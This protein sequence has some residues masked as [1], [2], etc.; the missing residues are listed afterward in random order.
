[1]LS[2]AVFFF[3]SWALVERGF[4][5][6]LLRRDNATTTLSAADIQSRDLVNIAAFAAAAYCVREG[7]WNCGVACNQVPD[8]QIAL[9]IG[10]DAATPDA[11][12]AYSSSRNQI[13]VGHEGT[14]PSQ[15]LS[16]E[17]DLQFA[18]TPLLT[19]LNVAGT[20]PGVE[21]HNGFQ[22][23]WVQTST[24]ILDAVQQIQ[25]QVPTASVLV[26]GHSLGAAVS[27]LDAIFLKQQLPSNTSIQVVGF[28]RPRVGNPAFADWV[29]S[30]FGS[31]NSFVVSR[32]DPVPHVPL[33]A[34]GF[35]H[36]SGEIWI[37]NNT[38]TL[39]CDGQEN[40]NCSDS[41]GVLDAAGGINDHLGPY[42][43]INMGHDSCSNLAITTVVSGTAV[44]TTAA[45]ITTPFSTELSLR[46]SAPTVGGLSKNGG[47]RI[48]GLGSTVG[49]VCALGTVAF[50]TVAG[51]L[52]AL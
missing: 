34:Q 39:A 6:P 30:M 26:T 29:D 36:A 37:E 8:T 27:L 50:G 40:P 23:A 47:H 22:T 7:T 44:T 21:V 35:Q 42:F 17:N 38:T 45:Q 13:I 25:A 20:P 48:G 33:L 51:A 31:N 14:D 19:I 1:M 12:V 11:Y 15:I 10:D 4:S 46:T 5:I 2:F 3:F 32:D 28:G 16:V 18:P 43:G 24:P 9:T 49:V 41:I 52:F